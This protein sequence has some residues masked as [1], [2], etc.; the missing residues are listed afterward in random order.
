MDDVLSPEP[1]RKR[2]NA[3][4]WS[5]AFVTPEV[6]RHIREAKHRKAYPMTG[7][8]V[9]QLLSGRLPTG[10]VNRQKGQRRG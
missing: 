8:M 7:E 3:R 4:G 1:R 5:A 2:Q 6:E 9:D 10:S